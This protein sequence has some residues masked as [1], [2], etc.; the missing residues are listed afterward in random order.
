MMCIEKDIKFWLQLTLETLM[1][2]ISFTTNLIPLYI[3]T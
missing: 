2:N 1:I 3:L